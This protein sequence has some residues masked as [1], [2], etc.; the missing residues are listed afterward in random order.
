MSKYNWLYFDLDNT[1]LDFSTASKNAF[2]YIFVN[3][4]ITMGPDDYQKYSVINHKV[5]VELEK[6]LISS[7]ELKIKRWSIFLEQEKINLDPKKI[8]EAYFLHLAYNPIF[9]NGAKDL[10]KSL[11]G[12]FN[13]ALV[14]NGLPEVQIPRLRLT[15]LDQTFKPIVISDEIGVAKPAAGFFDY[16]QNKCGHPLKEEVL[17]IGDTLTSDIR[18]GINYGFDTCWFN[19]N[20]ADN[21]TQYHANYEIS[22]IND[23]SEI[24]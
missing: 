20:S 9:V 24:L 12:K 1:L 16:V 22:R 7:E 13:L 8:N 2:Y 18:G 23:L 4:G 11:S 14:T 3:H 15:G 21:K 17:V 19:P 6:G 5:W 10:L